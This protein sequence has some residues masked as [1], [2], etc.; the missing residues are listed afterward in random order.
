MKLNLEKSVTVTPLCKP[1]KNVSKK[2]HSVKDSVIELNGLPTKPIDALERNKGQLVFPV[3]KRLKKYNTMDKV[4]NIAKEALKR[5]G[6][7]ACVATHGMGCRHYG[8]LDLK[9]MDGKNY[10]FYTKNGGWLDGKV[11]V[12]CNNK[13]ASMI[14]DKGSKSFVRYCEMG[15]KGMRFNRNGSED[16]INSYQDHHCNTILCISCWNT[17][18]EEYEQQ[19]KEL[20]GKTTL[21]SSAR[22][23][24]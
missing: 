19:V 15:L 1:P 21:R 17:K 22:H 7:K 14:M 6:G 20:K 12:D 3:R 2:N 16:D 5:G 13:T 24:L 18:V 9:P 8:I 10:H 4:S 11:C 23:K